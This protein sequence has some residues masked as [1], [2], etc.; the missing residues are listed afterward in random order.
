MLFKPET[1]ERIRN[2]KIDI[3]NN[4]AELYIANDFL[5]LRAISWQ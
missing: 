4:M 1:I 5:R 2:Q 3:H